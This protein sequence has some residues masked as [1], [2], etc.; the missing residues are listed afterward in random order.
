[1]VQGGPGAGGGGHGLGAGGS[2]EMAGPRTGVVD[3][4][5][6][7]LLATSNGNRTMKSF[8]LMRLLVDVS[9]QLVHTHH[10]H[11]DLD[12]ALEPF[13][14]LPSKSGM[15]NPRINLFLL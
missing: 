14:K 10:Q 13:D 9:K 12:G 8:L 11:Q 7:G 2:G 3:H 6:Q 4:V 5:D 15:L 1:M